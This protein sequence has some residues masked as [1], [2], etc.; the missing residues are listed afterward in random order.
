MEEL[1]TKLAP[2]QNN[3]STVVSPPLGTEA[4]ANG[5][6]AVW[7]GSVWNNNLSHNTW[8][9][10]QNLAI[11]SPRVARS[12]FPP[13]CAINAWQRRIVCMGGYLFDA[14]AAAWPTG[15]DVEVTSDIAIGTQFAPVP[16][17][18]T[19]YQG[20]T[21]QVTGVNQLATASIRVESIAGPPARV[22]I[23]IR[24]QGDAGGGNFVML[25]GLEW[26]Y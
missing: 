21:S 7:D 26:W 13:V 19:Y 25:D 9:A 10:W 16:G 5:E 3:P 18:L 2:F 24:F 4:F 17:G 20:A 1:E 15:S 22:G 23:F 14:A 11:R 8:T 6:P 12:G